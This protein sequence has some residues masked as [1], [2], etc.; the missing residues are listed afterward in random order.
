M[1]THQVLAATLLRLQTMTMHQHVIDSSP[2]PTSRRTWLGTML[3]VGVAASSWRSALAQPAGVSTI[4]PSRESTHPA[5]D[6]PVPDLPAIASAAFAAGRPLVVMFSLRGCPWCDA[7]R[8]EHFDALSK[9][10][11][12]ERVQVLELDLQD[13]R[14]FATQRTTESGSPGWLQAE[15]PRDLAR[16]SRVRFA[17]T[18]LFLGPNGELAE[19]LVGYGSPDFFGAYLEQ[20]LSQ[21]RS[22][23]VKR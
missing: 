1:P 16:Q 15:S 8:R 7:L 3:T 10:Q 17:P 2:S 12:D 14:R 18:I 21:S 11:D 6:R 23:L 22:A 4:G 20:R 5:P 13:A 19:R 9:R